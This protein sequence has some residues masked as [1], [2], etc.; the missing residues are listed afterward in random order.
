MPARVLSGSLALVLVALS[1]LARPAPTHAQHT[2]A[3]GY[4][5]WSVAARVG[6]SAPAGRYGEVRR[7]GAEWGLAVERSVVGILSVRGAFSQVR[8]AYEHTLVSDRHPDA[9]A[10]IDGG[11]GTSL[12]L[13]TAGVKLAARDGR[14]SRLYAVV[15]GGLARLS[16]EEATVRLSY[17]NLLGF[18]PSPEYRPLAGDLSETAPALAAAV[19]L[20]GRFRPGGRTRAGYFLEAG[21]AHARI[22]APLDAVQTGG[23]D[24]GSSAVLMRL[25]AGLSLGFGSQG[26]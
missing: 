13:F 12:S 16:Q 24:D 4:D 5:G 26:R 2:V 19:G 1:G 14:R 6:S 18:S 17:P 10:A 7:S 9:F 25:A 11:S 8:H 23:D 3:S 22:G 21:L 15:E 20:E